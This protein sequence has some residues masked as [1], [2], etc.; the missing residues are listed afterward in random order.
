M[1]NMS[2]LM[3]CFGVALL[4]ILGLAADAGVEAKIDPASYDCFKLRDGLENCRIKFE[5]EKKGRVAFLGGS[6][7]A[8]RWPG[9]AWHFSI[10]SYLKEKFP[11]TEFDFIQTGMDG[12]GTTPHA[13]RFARDVL[14]N[15]TVDLLFVEAA[16]NDGKQFGWMGYGAVNAVRGMEGIVRQ[17][18]LA[19]PFM[20]VVILHFA[21]GHQDDFNKG[22]TP[23]AIECHEKVAEYYGVP[24][25]NMAQEVARRERDGEFNWAK[26]F[27][28]IHP[29][30]FGSAVFSRSIFRM[31][32][33]AWKMPL[34]A[35]AQLKPC[36]L[37]AKP[38]D[39]QSYFRAK[40]V[41]IQKAIL[42]EG[43]R[44]V[45]NWKPAEGYKGVT[46][47]G[48]VNVPALVSEKPGST[49]HL[50]FTGTGVGL[51]GATGPDA[52]N[53]EYSIDGGAFKTC[54][55]WGNWCMGGYFACPV[56]LNGDLAPGAHELGLKVA[57]KSDPNSKGT[58]VQIMHFFVNQ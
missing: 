26:D 49:L 21:D 11:H 47:Y 53:F 1:K 24:S 27:S 9:N 3:T 55:P 56:V 8:A 38:L 52:G 6:I 39:E 7:T 58:A 34:A 32:D 12:Q 18:R 22:K 16:V 15:G 48:F 46:Q 14:K 51:W 4:P 19:N 36:R 10:R 43:W 5:R 23:P 37:P 28:G 54:C 20:D 2:Y 50:K 40:L 41:D 57:E 35:E 42:G 45:P 25:N 44:M 13:F 29:N 31:L 33:A 17:A 30:V